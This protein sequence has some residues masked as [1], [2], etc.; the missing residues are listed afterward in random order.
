MTIPRE[1]VADLQPGD[2][3]ELR[4]RSGSIVRGPLTRFGPGLGI[5]DVGRSVRDGGGY[6]PDAEG[7]TVISRAPRPLYVNHSRTTP[8]VGDVVRSADPANN[9]WMLISRGR[10]V[11]IDGNACARK[12]LPQRLV[13]LVDGLTGAV[14]Q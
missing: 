14:V 3:V 9:Q 13:L 4:F 1:Q 6:P 2:V 7:L 8:V 10:W 11:S 5:A 12:E